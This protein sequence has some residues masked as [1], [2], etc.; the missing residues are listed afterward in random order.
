MV[1]MTLKA[2]RKAVTNMTDN[3]KLSLFP[4]GES[5]VFMNVNGY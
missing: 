1:I 3:W 4:T 2:L 5:M